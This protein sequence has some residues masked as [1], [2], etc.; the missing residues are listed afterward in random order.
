MQTKRGVFY[1]EAPMSIINK[2]ITACIVIAAVLTNY[3]TLSADYTPFI[4]NYTLDGPSFKYATTPLW[5]YLRLGLNY[6]ESPK[7]LSPPKTVSPKY[8]HPDGKGF[9]AYGF[10]PQAYQDVQRLYPFFKQH[11]WQEIMNSPRLYDLANQAFADWLL[12]NLQEYI[13]AQATREEI[14]DLLHQAWNL[15]LTGFK[16]GK[17]VVASRTKRA[18]EFKV[19]WQTPHELG[20]V[21]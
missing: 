20:S 17:K 8:V 21:I 18:Q 1:Y 12:K 7:P 13:P 15:G 11:S 5:Q 3:G 19:H 9:G 10:S 16:N 6:L 14:F 4:H 2:I